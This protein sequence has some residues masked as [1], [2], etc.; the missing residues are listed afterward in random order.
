MNKHWLLIT[1]VAHNL[2]WDQSIF[3]HHKWWPTGLFEN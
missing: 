1:Q 3:T 2:L